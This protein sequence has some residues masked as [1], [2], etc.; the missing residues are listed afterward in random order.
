MVDVAKPSPVYLTDRNLET[1]AVLAIFLD[2]LHG[3]RL[4][5]PNDLTTRRIRELPRV[6]ELAVKYDCPFVL[7]QLHL[8]LR[9]SLLD[10]TLNPFLT[11]TLLS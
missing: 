7:R 5:A 6:Y 8:N 1:A 4:P 11:F 2:L 9:S 10:G 3:R